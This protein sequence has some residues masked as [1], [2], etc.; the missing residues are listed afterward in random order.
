LLEEFFCDMQF[1]A[2]PWRGKESQESVYWV[3]WR[4]QSR[5]KEKTM[6]FFRMSSFLL[7]VS[8]MALA[9]GTGVKGCNIPT[10]EGSKHV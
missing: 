4:S 1:V 6:V 10:F 7:V 2:V 3:E 5:M 9:S 8:R